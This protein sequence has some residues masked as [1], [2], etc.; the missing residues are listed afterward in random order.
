LVEKQTLMKY[1]AKYSAWALA[2]FLFNQLTLEIVFKWN[3]DSAF[4]ISAANCSRFADTKTM[5]EI[6]MSFT[7]LDARCK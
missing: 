6:K 1:V 3:M 2:V 7:L 5:L 4:L